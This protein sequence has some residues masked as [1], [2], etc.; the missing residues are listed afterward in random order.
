MEIS[1][2]LLENGRFVINKSDDMGN[3]MAIGMLELAKKVM[4]EP[5]E[6]DSDQIKGQ[7]SLDEITDDMQ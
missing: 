1:I 2:K 5:E 4:L 3:F 6:E 7:V